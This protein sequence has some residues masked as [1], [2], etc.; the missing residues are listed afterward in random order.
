ML[1]INEQRPP[2][3]PFTLKTAKLKIRMAE[4]GWD[5]QNPEKVALAYTID[6]Q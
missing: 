2:L 6:S 4:D 3:P 1:T 5:I